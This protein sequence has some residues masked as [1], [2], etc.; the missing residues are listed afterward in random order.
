MLQKILKKVTMKKF[1]NIAAYKL[2]ALTEL[3]LMRARLLA[4]CTS[5][6]LKG[7][8]LL[9]P[10]GIV[11]LNP[12]A[13]TIVERCDGRTTVEAL[14]ECLASEYEVDAAELRADVLQCLRELHARHLQRTQEKANGLQI[15]HINGFVIG[16]IRGQPA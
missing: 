9:S 11:V 6:G 1:T 13:Q 3:R 7:T 12:T 8:I 16:T 14:T 2:A 4:L 10:E 15:A 5:W